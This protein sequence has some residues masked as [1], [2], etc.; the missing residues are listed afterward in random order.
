MRPST[1]HCDPVAGVVYNQDN[2]PVGRIDGRGYIELSKGGYVGLAHRFIWEFVHGPI[3]A[4]MQ[5]NHKN[6]VKH[7]NRIEN[8]ELVTPSQNTLHAYRTNLMSAV[9]ET[10]GRAKL[11]SS[12]VVEIRRL[13]RSLP[14]NSIAMRYGVSSRTVRDI[15]SK[16]RWRHVA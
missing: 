8:L 12:E 10:N 4:S 13:H 9:G 2:K 14:V 7:D 5:V 11:T 1:Y 3:P 6:G 15:V 16:R